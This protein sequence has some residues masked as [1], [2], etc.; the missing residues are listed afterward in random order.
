MTDSQ[1]SIRTILPFIVGLIGC[2]FLAIVNQERGFELWRNYALSGLGMGIP[3]AAVLWYKDV[4]L[5]HYIQ[6]VIV[7]GI[8]LHYGGG[9]LGSPD[10]YSM[11][12]F[13]FHGINGAYH[14]FDWWDHLTHAAGVGAGTMASAYLVEVYQAR[15]G[16]A[17]SAKAVWLVA[18]MMG[19]AMGVGVEL[20]EYLGKAVFQTIDQG[21][22]ENTMRDLHYN[23]LG[24]T[25][26]GA[27]AANVD[28]R[29]W[30]RAIAEHWGAPSETLAN[31]PWQTRIPPV[32]AGLL[33]FVA[34]AAVMTVFL[35]VRFILQDAP[36]H[37]I[38]AYDDALQLMLASAIAG[39]VV[40]GPGNWAMRKVVAKEA[41]S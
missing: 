8:W 37:D 35:A 15:R 22:Y 6:W 23:I 41:T 17:W 21:G 40:A 34:P 14:V 9:T 38:A 11:G 25:I 3:V 31:A 4:R 16:L 32:M 29:R 30:S 1:R 27:I 2:A 26:G 39:I 18:V 20:Y 5:P 33:A 28:R 12:L 13:G 10:P 24:A 36:E 7:G 19:L